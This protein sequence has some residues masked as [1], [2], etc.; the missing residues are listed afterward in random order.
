MNADGQLVKTDSSGIGGGG[1]VV[2]LPIGS[3]LIWP[4]AADTIPSG[5][6]PMDGR[7]LN[8]VVYEDLFGLIGTT[9]GA[10]D[11]STTFNIPNSK[12][13]VIT[14]LDSSQANFNA[15]GRTA[16]A[17]T[18]SHGLGNGYAKVFISGNYN[19]YIRQKNVANWNSNGS[20]NGTSIG[21]GTGSSSAELG[22][23][24]DSATNLQPGIT[25]QYII[26]II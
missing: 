10:G 21:S 24:T 26:R 2:G 7:A 1:G 23:S 11:N 19:V 12:G 14:G 25:M 15:L 8:R 5:Y 9:Y 17:L 16:G 22:G 13:R 3:T 6:V 4:G 20:A 18:H